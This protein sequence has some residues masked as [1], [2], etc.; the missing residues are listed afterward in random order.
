MVIRDRD[1]WREIWSEIYKWNRPLPTLPEIDFARGMVVVVGMGE[2][3]STGFS[4]LVDSAYERDD[5][6]EV[7]VV[8]ESPKHC[9]ELT[10]MTNP[11]DIVRLPKIE[12]PVIFHETEIVH[13]CSH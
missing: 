6:L 2:R 11:L 4:I 7:D 10:V 8:S 5:Q 1:A 13:D 12:R 9:I 3:P